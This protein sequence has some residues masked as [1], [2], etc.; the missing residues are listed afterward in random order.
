[1][2]TCEDG[3]KS[4]QELI[5]ELTS[6]RALV[7]RLEQLTA[8]YREAEKLQNALYEI[9]D[10]ASSAEDMS[11]FYGSLHRIIGSLMYAKN[12]YVAL[13]EKD[14][15]LVRFPYFED[16][17]DEIVPDELPFER[18]ER[19]MTAWL[20]RHGQ[21]ALMTR[22]DLIEQSEKGEIEV[23]GELPVM[24]MGAPLLRNRSGF[25]AIVVQSYAEQ[26]RYT[27]KD[28]ELLNFVSQHITTALE[29]KL[30]R[31]EL[32]S[33]VEERTRDLVAANQNLQLE[34]RERERGERLQASLF[35]IAELSNV[36]LDMDE[37]YRRLH[38]IVAELTYARNFYIAIYD[39]A[40]GMITFPYMV[41][42]LDT[43]PRP[44]STG[45]GLTEYLIRRGDPV[46]LDR[47]Q[48]A[49]LERAGEI[50]DLGGRC[51]HWLGVPLMDGE[52]VIGVLAVQ[53]YDDDVR[54][55][56]RDLE[57]MTF[58]SHHIAGALQ[59]KQA[60]VALEHAYDELERRVQ[61]RTQELYEAN[62]VLED[63]IKERKRIERRLI[64]DALHDALTGLPNRNLFQDRLI[65]AI[66][67]MNR[68]ADFRFAVLFLDLDRFKVINDS[69][70]HLVGDQ[71]LKEVSGRILACMRESD[72]VARLGGD[73]F[74]I[75]LESLSG[76]TDARKTATRI[77]ERLSEPFELGD[78]EVF[79]ST[80]IG[81][82]FGNT[83]YKKPEDLLRDA[84]AAMYRAKERG[85]GRIEIFDESMHAQAL[86]QLEMESYL[87][88]AV[89]KDEL[90]IHYQPI[91]NLET[92][93]IIGFEALV[94]WQHPYKDLL[95]PESFLPLAVET[96]VI[97]TFD[98]WVLEHAI[99]QM[100][101]WRQT[102]PQHRPLELHVNISGKLL[103]QPDFAADLANLLAETGLDPA[104]LELEVNESALLE[105]QSAAEVFAAFQQMGVKL[106]LDDFGTE[107]TSIR[108]LHEFP[109][110]TIKIDR[111]FVTAMPDREENHAI[112]RTVAALGEILGMRVIAE[113]IETEA[114]LTEIRAL[115][116][117]FGQ[118]FHLAHP[119]AADAATE[120]LLRAR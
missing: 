120:L 54:F 31:A 99:K 63:Q 89:E 43:Q 92:R 35:R 50:K 7:P 91:V 105:T 100:Q 11:H 49:A 39:P 57:L 20:M 71:L 109:M 28:L 59:R 113:G 68:G 53:S 5:D 104:C 55:E 84:D 51:L 30:A 38:Q 72:T 37:F 90:R 98:R 32:E 40:T 97:Q 114:H 78:Q 8:E 47:D 73:E 6:M 36:S 69:L 19:G 79:T 56:E 10:L 34:I 75:L 108:L 60:T 116:C 83:R 61:E 4:K 12:F 76:A 111:T 82:A 81:I 95:V 88:R 62:R 86:A 112:T 102:F 41:D 107:H 18:I 22:A 27:N 14:S 110:D 118:G 1:M 94:R 44:R 21:S 101:H 26:H 17:V 33:R 106:L 16:T 13:Y 77:L 9:A 85:R 66:K 58:V 119:L 2:I 48:L 25:G 96:G 3:N 117:H 87:H 93:A 45:Q 46:L 65:H 42:E 115:G 15:G 64:H 29:R 52:E 74:A 80:S 103:Q 24:W 23:V 70:G 67:R